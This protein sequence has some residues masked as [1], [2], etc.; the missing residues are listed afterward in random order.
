MKIKQTFIKMKKTEYI[1]RISMFIVLIITYLIAVSCSDTEEPIIQSLAPVL[2]SENINVSENI[3]ETFNILTLTATDN[4]TEATSLVYSIV[5][6]SDDLFE[7]TMDSTNAIISLVP[8]AVLDY[9]TTIVHEITVEVS[10]GEN[11]AT[12][13]FTINVTDIDDTINVT[14]AKFGVNVPV[15]SNHYDFSTIAEIDVT[16]YNEN[17]TYELKLKGVYLKKE[18]TL[19]LTKKNDLEQPVKGD[20][21]IALQKDTESLKSITVDPIKV[22]IENESSTTTL[23]VNTTDM[24]WDTDEYTAVL[25]EKESNSEIVIAG[26]NDIST[27]V[28]KQA[29]G[30][31]SGTQL[32]SDDWTKLTELDLNDH[33]SFRVRPT[34]V[35]Y[36][37][38]IAIVLG[39][40]D[41]DANKIGYITSNGSNGSGSGTYSYKFSADKLNDLITSNGTYLLRLEERTSTIDANDAG[42]RNALFQKINI[43]KITNKL[44]VLA[45]QK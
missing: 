45:K 12:G 37:N 41:I 38:G 25:I 34:V 30:F 9:E 5:E 42:Y 32:E 44:A 8:G 4:D 15:V 21:Q 7:L 1:S 39:V 10:D 27:V 33:S 6:N 31:L 3:S 23:V 24:D 11:T 18:Y 17:F 43:Q 28:N 14:S 26:N 16:D 40:Y 13:I 36:I 29:T 35:N 20:V 19:G 22:S 2:E